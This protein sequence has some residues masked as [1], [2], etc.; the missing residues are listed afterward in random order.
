MIMFKNIRQSLITRLMLYFILAGFAVVVLFSINIAFGL[1]V[2]FKNE[3]LPNIAQYLIYIKDDIGIP[4]NLIKAKKLSQDLSIKIFITGPGINWKSDELMPD[5]HTLAFEPA[6]SPYQKY[7]IAH[8][9]KHNFVLIEDNQFNY[10]FSVSRLAS[11]PSFTRNISLLAVLIFFMLLLF[12]AIRK[13][14]KPLKAIS[15]GVK[16]IAQGNLESN[17]TIQNSYEFEQLALGINSMATELNTMLEAKQQLLLAISHE[18]RSPITR[19]QVNLA[20]LPE[21]D[22]Q[23][24]LKHDLLE[25]EHLISQI[26]E[27]QRLNQTHSALNKTTFQLDDLIHQTVQTYFEGKKI[28]LKLSSISINADQTRFMLLI[29]NLI[30]N[31]LKYSTHSSSAPV[32]RLIKENR[33]LKLEIE[34][35]GIGMNAEDLDKITQAFY[36]I[37]QARQRSTGGFGL[38]LYLSHLIVKAH[39]A[40][41]TFQ[42]KMGQGTQVIIT[43]TISA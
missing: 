4:P 19:A 16:E 13:S 25:M 6:P 39:G 24:A 31:A 33:G 26:L 5:I 3:I 27:S 36:R 17:I 37:D 20:L 12:F 2:H 35:F 38:G 28:D 22:I 21:D 29:K 40:N 18:L 42:S 30:D 34:D 43:M 11:S 1:K 8:R 32:I 9:H 10:Y 41:M 23:K 7:K 14:L 15:S